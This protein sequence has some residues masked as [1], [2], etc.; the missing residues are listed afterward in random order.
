MRDDSGSRYRHCLSESN[1]AVT[2]RVHSDVVRPLISVTAVAA[3]L[4]AVPA[5]PSPAVAAAPAGAN[6]AAVLAGLTEAQRVGQL[7]MV[8][9]SLSGVSQTTKDAITRYHVGSVILAGRSSVGVASIRRMTGGLQKLATASA[10]GGIPLFVAT[11]QEGGQV[12]TLSGPG[13]STIPTAVRQGSFSATTLRTDWVRWGGQLAAAGVNLDLAPVL[14]TVPAGSAST[15]QPIGR[16]QREYGTKPSTVTAA[17]LSVVRGLHVAGVEATVKHFP[18]L[19]RASGNTDTTYGVVDTVTTRHDAYIKPYAVATRTADAGVVMVSLA[20][21]KQIDA[22]HRAVFSPTVIGGMLRH[23]LGFTGVVI[24]DAMNAVALRDVSPGRRAV[25]FVGAGGDLALTDKPADI[26]AMAT[27]LLS[28][29]SSDARFRAKVDAACL[30]VLI[31]KQRLGLVAGAVAAAADSSRLYLA[32]QTATHHV[33]V[34]VRD[35]NGWSAPVDLGG[36]SARA[37]ALAALPGGGVEV[38][39]VSGSRSV[40]VRTYVPGGASSS[41]QDIGGTATSPPTVAVDAHGRIAVAARFGDG[42]LHLREHVPGS[43]WGAWSSLGGAF[44]AGA[45]ALTF[46]PSGD[47][48]AYD[49]GQTQIVYRKIRH[50]G[51]WSGWSS[52]AGVADSGLAVAAASSGDISLLTRGSNETLQLLTSGTSGWH[53]VAGARPAG[54]PAA[55]QTAADVLTVV[56]EGT[57]GKLHLATRSGSTWSAWSVLPF[58]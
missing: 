45:P 21:Y 49:V 19:G 38:A 44:T 24:S 52:L 22:R 12:Q 28:R 3:A 11:D 25:R 15:N 31:A 43:G 57:D 20:T 7:L 6:A 46:L 18:G 33:T 1:A 5:L 17:G 14:D 2:T 32:E 30:R 37:P 55:A 13:F 8:S 40:A 42:R 35:R 56:L 9:A 54:A 39:R 47:L 36:G 50:G 58:D 53:P 4:L 41:W 26:K 27:A 48:A 29:A 16:Y 51:S 23:D 10:T 34:A